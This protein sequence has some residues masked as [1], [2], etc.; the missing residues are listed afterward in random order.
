[1]L[2][3]A[4]SEVIG[5]A[6][7]QVCSLFA[8]EIDALV[9]QGLTQVFNLYRRHTNELLEQWVERVDVTG[10]GFMHCIWT[11]EFLRGGQFS[12]SRPLAHGF[13]AVLAVTFGNIGL[14]TLQSH[15]IATTILLDGVNRRQFERALSEHR[16]INDV[17]TLIDPL[18]SVTD[19]RYCG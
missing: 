13:L 14:P 15:Y 2:S 16:L 18:R 5:P 12:I 19:Q 7:V 4:L 17:V 3:H 9:R 6:D 10:K 11:G 8:K 1:M